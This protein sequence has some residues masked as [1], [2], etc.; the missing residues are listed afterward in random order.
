MVHR[1]VADKVGRVWFVGNWE[2]GAFF[3]DTKTNSW[4]SYNPGNSGIG[5][6]IGWDITTDSHNN[7]YFAL[8]GPADRVMILDSTL[9]TWYQL[10][11]SG[12][13]HASDMD[14]GPDG[15]IY[16]SFK[17]EG[18]LLIDT[19]GTSRDITDD[20]THFYTVDEGMPSVNCQAVK[21][22]KE[23]IVFVATE[24]GIAVLD[25]DSTKT[26]NTKNSGLINDDC[27]ALT[28]DSEGRVWILTRA[29][30]SIYNPYFDTWQRI[31]FSENHL[32]IRFT[33]ERLDTKAFLFDAIHHCIWFGSRSGLLRITLSAPPPLELDSALVYPNPLTRNDHALIFKKLPTDA[34]IYIFSLS[35][36]LVKRLDNYDANIPGYVWFH[37]E[38]EL[39]SGLYF[40]LIKTPSEKRIIKFGVVK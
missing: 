19:R 23:N 20:S 33:T 13:G 38:Q 22:D 28:I 14:V 7:M 24:A 6:D 8:A 11:P 17:T 5:S 10:N 37:A 2:G 26:L 18:L 30:I 12:L 4:T 21:V 27:L 9:T 32:T 25:K 35:G 39:A 40:A 34:K 1:C 3:Y 15:R 36:R 16:V 29:G 31:G